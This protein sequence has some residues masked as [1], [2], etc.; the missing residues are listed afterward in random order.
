MQS[1]Q[2]QEHRASISPAQRMIENGHIF[3]WLIKDTCWVSEWKIAGLSMIVP[4]LGVAVYILCKAWHIRS[5]RFHNTAICLWIC[6]NSIWMIGEFF[7]LETRTYTAALFVSGLA[8]I[9]YYYAFILPKELRLK[10]VKQ[11]ALSKNT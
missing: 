5:E 4:T 10:T 7:E 6:G 1:A 11:A 2:D 3:L 9:L 8:L